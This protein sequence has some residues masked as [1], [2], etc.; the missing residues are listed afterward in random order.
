MERGERA[1]DRPLTP[2]ICTASPSP[3]FVPVSATLLIKSVLNGGSNGGYSIGLHALAGSVARASGEVVEGWS[4]CC[5]LRGSVACCV[6]RV[7]CCMV[8]ADCVLRVRASERYGVGSSSF[9]ESKKKSKRAK[10]V[11]PPP[12]KKSLTPSRYDASTSTAPSPSALCP[13]PRTSPLRI[14]PGAC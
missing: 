8:C 11:P 2:L 1:Q 7:A 10:S 4:A 12:H 13:S 3:W 9:H 5:A 6:V 14:R